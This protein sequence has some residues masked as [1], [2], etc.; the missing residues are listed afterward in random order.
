MDNWYW[1]NDCPT[2]TKSIRTTQIRKNG[3]DKF[4]L[5]R[6]VNNR[7]YKKLPR[8]TSARIRDAIKK[9]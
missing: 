8:M 5:Y 1:E 6:K 7:E 4:D 3:E 2:L 9:V